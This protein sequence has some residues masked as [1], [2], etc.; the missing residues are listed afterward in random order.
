L[1][2]LLKNGHLSAKVFSLTKI[3]EIDCKLGSY[4]LFAKLH[5]ETFS[6]RPIINCRN[7]PASKISKMLDL[8]L[9][10]IVMKTESFIKD[11]Q[12]LIQKCQ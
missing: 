7:H 11:S 8:I 4:R 3:R 1:E 5:I 2:N 6:W 10:P 12:N 9:K